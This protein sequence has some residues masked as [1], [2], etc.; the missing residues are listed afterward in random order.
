MNGIV[1]SH[2]ALWNCRSCAKYWGM[3]FAT[4][5]AVYIGVL[6]SD[7]MKT[8]LNGFFPALGDKPCTNCITAS[9]SEYRT[10]K[11]MRAV[12][13][14]AEAFAAIDNMTAHAKRLIVRRLIVTH[15]S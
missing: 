11:C 5:S 13:C 2:E 1:R 3:Y 10:S 6:N 15:P 4:T 7:G 12:G 9:C 8:L 14:C